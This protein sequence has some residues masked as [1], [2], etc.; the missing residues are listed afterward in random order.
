MASGSQ[1]NIYLGGHFDSKEIQ[2]PRGQDLR[3]EQQ[4]MQNA[5]QPMERANH[6]CS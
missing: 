2:P 5:N 6:L 3:G 4:E 1:G